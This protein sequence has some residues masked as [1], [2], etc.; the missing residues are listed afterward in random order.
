MLAAPVFGFLAT[1]LFRLC[2]SP[3]TMMP[4]HP[5]MRFHARD[6]RGPNQSAV[7]EDCGIQRLMCSANNP[8]HLNEIIRGRTFDATYMH[9]MHIRSVVEPTRRFRA[10]IG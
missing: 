2:A 8:S 5:V 7:I 6:N 4:H 3:F 9:W 10:Q 1:P